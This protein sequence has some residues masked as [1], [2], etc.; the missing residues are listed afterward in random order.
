MI[1]KSQLNIVFIGTSSNYSIC[2]LNAMLAVGYTVVGILDSHRKK[3]KYSLWDKRMLS[4]SS[5]IKA[6]GEIDGR[7]TDDLNS[8]EI[9]DY[10]KST[11]CN[12]ICVASA[13]QLLKENIIR[14][15]KYGVL[16]AHTA[17]LPDYRGPNPTYWVFRNGETESGVTIHYID[18]GEDTG[19][20][21]TQERFPITFGMTARE[22]NEAAN[23][24]AVKGYLNALS[25]L[26]S[27]TI[28]RKKQGNSTKGRAR[29]VI[30]EDFLLNYAEWDVE[31]AWS[32]LR[33]TDGI[34][35]IY[36]SLIFTYDIKDCQKGGG[37]IAGKYDIQCKNG[38]LSVNRRFQPVRAAKNII[39]TL[40]K[41][42][43]AKDN[44]P[45]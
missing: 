3:E 28:V 27:G 39:K 34:K 45:R 36:D 11:H 16:N 32:F 35:Q 13:G 14:I 19:D 43:G 18:V 38:I 21:I 10:I 33:G 31:R 17:L 1:E 4:R 25:M 6:G 22:Y 26:E 42:G 23:C 40:C 15:P 12:L 9:E 7:I 24:A 2:C 5:L 30:R 29:N 8:H 41:R 37:S 20:I 44:L